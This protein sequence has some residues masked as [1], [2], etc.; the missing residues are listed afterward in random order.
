MRDVHTLLC[1]VHIE[2]LSRCTSN[3]L[4]IGLETKI[5]YSDGSDAYVYHEVRGDRVA[6]VAIP[7]GPVSVDHGTGAES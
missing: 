5:V 2:E 7:G 6:E 4:V 3:H 1:D